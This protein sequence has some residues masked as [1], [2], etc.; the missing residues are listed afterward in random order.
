MVSIKHMK[1]GDVLMKEGEVSNSMYWVQTGTLRLFKKKGS[2]FIELGV[3]HSGEVVGEMSFLDS[4]PRSASVEALQPCDIVEI[5][6]GKFDEF[7]NA[8]PSW[9]KSLVQTLVKRLRSTNNRLRELENASTV[10][11]KDEDGRTTKVHEF[12]STAEQLKLSS[13][14]L[15][16]AARNGEKGTNGAP[17]IKAGWLQFYGSQ[18]FGAQLAKVQ[19]FT[20][21]LHEAGVIRI[22]KAAD[23]V[24]LYLQD[25]DRLEKFI[26][27]SHEDNGK[28]EDKQLP[29]TAKGTAILNAVAEFG[30]INQAPPGTETLKVNVDDVFTQAATKQGLKVPFEL[31]AFEELVKAGFCADVR[32]DGSGKTCVFQVA[33][34]Q[35]LQPLVSLRQRFRDLNVQKRDA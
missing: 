35:K 26:Y 23:Q 11:A 22:E 5:P 6:R 17:K 33:R 4:Q 7:L 29:V 28:T 34:F 3:V 32:A 9:M 25:V 20:D 14:L 1:K 13:A 21:V 2:G 8:Q 15:L 19:A 16:A 10:Y 24:D 12:L 27:F 18:I 30:G 31:T